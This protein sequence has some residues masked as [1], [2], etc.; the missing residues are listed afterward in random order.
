MMLPDEDGNTPLHY[1][2]LGGSSGLVKF[3]LRKSGGYVSTYGIHHFLMN[4][5]CIFI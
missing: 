4:S 1:A 3:I 2:V 5:A